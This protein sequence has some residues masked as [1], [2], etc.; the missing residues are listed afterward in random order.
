M[1]GMKGGAKI[2]ILFDEDDRLIG[3]AFH[4]KFEETLRQHDADIRKKETNDR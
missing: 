3:G 1:Q 2:Q 4:P